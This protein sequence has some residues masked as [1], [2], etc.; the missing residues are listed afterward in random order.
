MRSIRC[1][2]SSWLALFAA[3]VALVWLVLPPILESAR[4]QD[5][6]RFIPGAPPVDAELSY[7]IPLPVWLVPTVL[8]LKTEYVDGLAYELAW[9]AENHTE[10]DLSVL[11]EAGAEL[12]EAGERVAGAIQAI[13]GLDVTFGIE[14]ISRIIPAEGA[15]RDTLFGFVVWHESAS[16]NSREQMTNFEGL[17]GRVSA[18]GA[19][20]SQLSDHLSSLQAGVAEAAEAHDS[21]V[22]AELAPDIV[23]TATNI[24]SVCRNLAGLSVELAELIAEM[25]EDSPTLLVEKWQAA[26][27]ATADCAAPVLKTESALAAISDVLD[28]LTELTDIV[29]HATDAVDGMSVEPNAE[30]LIYISWTMLNDDWHVMDHLENDVILNEESGCPYESKTRLRALLPKSVEAN[31]ILAGK[32]VE[33]TSAEM[34]RA[35]NA[36]EDYYKR[37]TGFDPEA[38][39]RRKKKALEK[40]DKEMRDNLELAAGTIS[41]RAAIRALDEGRAKSVLGVGSSWDALYE[42]NNAWLHCLN[43]GASALRVSDMASSR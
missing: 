7:N 13:G 12:G 30:G 22:I 20:A 43:A 19:A 9:I 31:G 26:A 8:D 17:V 6:V 21:R 41:M 3:L 5:D 40:V 29:E 27:D 37:R 11:V 2:T 24:D 10:E 1:R 15:L 38:S 33:H 42:Y 35:I 25:S 14:G 39:D 34:S 16:G 4:A 23:E 18:G 28:V 36:I 32:A